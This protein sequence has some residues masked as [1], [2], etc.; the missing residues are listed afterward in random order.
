M[1]LRLP[2]FSTTLMRMAFVAICIAASAT[3]EAQDAFRFET[4]S[5]YVRANRRD[6]L[7]IGVRGD[8]RLVANS[9]QHK[10]EVNIYDAGRL[11]D[12]YTTGIRPLCNPD[13]VV[14]DNLTEMIVEDAGEGR[15]VGNALRQAAGGAKVVVLLHDGRATFTLPAREARMLAEVLKR[16]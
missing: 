8:H 5:F 6:D 3:A 11:P 15:M 12:G 14:N 1:T 9:W 10:M 4:D 13:F 16:R 7:R 2:H